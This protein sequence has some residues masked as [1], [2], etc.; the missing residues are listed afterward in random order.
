MTTSR[1]RSKPRGSR[2]DLLIAF[3]CVVA[4]GFLTAWTLFP[5]YGTGQFVLAAATAV[6][7]GAVLGALAGWRGWPTWLV[8][9]AG[10]GTYLLG[11]MLTAM[12]TLELDARSLLANVRS[13]LVGPFIGWRGVVTLPT[14]LG[15]YLGVMVPGYALLFVGALLA[16]LVALRA[17]RW[18]LGPT[19]AAAGLIV[20]IVVGPAAVTRLGTVAGLRVS[21]QLTIGLAAFG[22]LLTWFR[23]HESVARRKVR[24]EAKD[25]PGRT[26]RRIVTAITALVMVIVAVAAAASATVILPS[27]P[28]TV[29][30]AAAEVAI[31]VSDSQTPLDYYRSFYADEQIDSTLFRVTTSAPAGRVRLAVL[32]TYDGDTFRPS[33]SA[34]DFRRL[35]AG[36]R[37]PSGATEVSSQIIIEGLTGIWTPVVGDVAKV[38]FGGDRAAELVDGFYFIPG[39]GSAVTVVDSSVAAGDVFNVTGGVTSAA[40]L[41]GRPSG[42]AN[43]AESL[44]PEELVDWVEAQKVSADGAGLMEL[45]SR[46]RARGYV[47]HA[48]AAP[49]EGQ[50]SWQTALGE[51]EFV[52][53]AAGHSYAR[54]GA[55]FG[56]LN[57]RASEVG[58][59]ASDELL[60]SAVGDDEQFAAA[61]AMLAMYLGFEARVVVGARL[62][63]SDP[64]GWAPEP[65]QAGVC[66]GGNISAWIEVSTPEGWVSVDTSP[67]D[68]SPLSPEVTNQSDP[69]FP[70]AIDEDTAEVTEPPQS[71]RSRTGS[72]NSEEENANQG[73]IELSAP[74]RY[75]AAGGL[76]VLAL[77]LPLL[78]V[79]VVKV[80]RA[81]RRRH[82]EGPM[83]AR[84]AWDELMDRAADARLSPPVWATRQEAAAALGTTNAIALA[85]VADR[86][87]FD[88]RG[89]SADEAVEAWRLE[90]EDS[91]ELAA[92]LG[93]WSRLRARISLRS[94]WRG[95]ARSASRSGG[96]GRASGATWRNDDSVVVERARAKTST[97]GKKGP[98]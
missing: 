4:M 61:S 78:A 45:I 84:G 50:Y 49:P 56:Q 87:I 43:Y 47:S 92:R 68:E 1:Q 71:E 67:Q 29:A 8:V 40:T 64:A 2:A 33:A 70:S 80:I 91:R 14:P 72:E 52:A 7:T 75:V 5:V 30:R 23:A 94:L 54:I 69:Q 25:A 98:Q 57:E 53:A 51:H 97:H 95:R 62:S 79:H 20:A 65:C 44:F 12:P 16:M 83:A 35:A 6:A 74:V 96:A 77:I 38:G 17:R 76:L 3:G 48:M 41:E 86:A 81:N 66:T 24:T 10:F 88:A 93:F 42:G 32:D 90:H 58:N 34:G 9:L 22:V 63:D 60:I 85:A 39:G 36:V 37:L 55:L 19:V 26:A 73:S 31:S 82:A 11:V 28:R 59:G 18:W 21:S 46:L 13:A 89:V 27:P 15:N